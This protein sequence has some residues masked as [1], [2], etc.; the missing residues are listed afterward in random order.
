MLDVKGGS[1][2]NGASIILFDYHGRANQRWVVKE[3]GTILNLQSGKV[4]DITGGSTHSGAKIVTFTTNGGV[5]Q[6]WQVSDGTIKNPSTGK[7]LDIPNFNYN[8][9][10][11]IILWEEEPIRSGSWFPLSYS[12]KQ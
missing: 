6:K 11:E 4:L 2:A 12:N 9:G 3:D 5:S 10:T 7:V 8:S 1:I